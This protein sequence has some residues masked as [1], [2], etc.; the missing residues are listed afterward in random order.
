MSECPTATGAMCPSA[1]SQLSKAPG[2]KYQSKWFGSIFV[3]L[4]N[5]K[6]RFVVFFV[7]IVRVPFQ[8]QSVWG[9]VDFGRVWSWDSDLCFW[10]RSPF[11]SISYC[12]LDCA[13]F[14]VSTT[15]QQRRKSKHALWRKA[16]RDELHTSKSTIVFSNAE[17]VRLYK[18]LLFIS[19]LLLLLLRSLLLRDFWFLSFSLTFSS[20]YLPPLLSYCQRSFSLSVFRG[21]FVHVIVSRQTLIENF[22]LCVKL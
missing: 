20:V 13:A 7:S 1:K 3:V 19:S 21:V 8:T 2:G 17:R 12:A 6:D 22:S 9:W 10:F 18:R 4:S 14:K 15:L 16:G 11:A 5:W